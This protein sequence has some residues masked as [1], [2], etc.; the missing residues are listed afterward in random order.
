MQKQE[1]LDWF[2]TNDFQ[3]ARALGVIIALLF[4]VGDVTL[5]TT[6]DNEEYEMFP[7]SK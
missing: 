4:M 3:R 7:G 5:A 1:D 6:I 2:Y